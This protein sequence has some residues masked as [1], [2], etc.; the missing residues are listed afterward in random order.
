LFNVIIVASAP[1]TFIMS[2]APVLSLPT[3]REFTAK[4]YLACP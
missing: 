2:A 1:S 3:E 4:K